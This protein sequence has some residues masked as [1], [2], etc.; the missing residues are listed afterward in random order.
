VADVVLNAGFWH[1]RRVLVTGHTGFKG[2]WLALWLTAA[3]ADVTG[4]SLRPPTAPCLFELARAGELIESVEGDV[5]DVD[6]V[7]GLIA[8]RRPE[9]VFHLAAQPLVRRSYEIP[10]DTFETNVLGTAGVLEAVRRSDSVRVVVVVTSDKVYEDRGWV[11]PYREP[12]RLGGSDPYSASKACAE[13]ITAA[14][15]SSF[16]TGVAVGSARAG[17]VFGGGDFAADRLV[18]DAMRAAASGS[19]LVVRNPGSLRPWQHVLNAVG[20]YMTLAERLWDDPALAGPWNFGP[21]AS[22]VRPV[23]WIADRLRSLWEGLEWHVEEDA[24]APHETHSLGV[25]SSKARSL[26]GWSPRWDLEAGLARTVDWHRALE[27]GDDVRERTLEQ[28]A[29]FA[30]PS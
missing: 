15:R 1:G 21:A 30:R 10:Y 4:Y 17:N 14:Y 27:E 24:G 29:A 18:P 7:A 28:I 25:D 5:R 13:L 8:D 19:D 22:D 12:D 9:V 16:L 2:S 3:D 6:R 20:G 23:S 11:W 26:L